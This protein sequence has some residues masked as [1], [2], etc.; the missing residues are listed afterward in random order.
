MSRALAV[1]SA[2]LVL[3]L[4][5]VL[6][7]CAGGTPA[8]APSPSPSPW[9][10]WTPTPQPTATPT[11]TPTPTVT[12]SPTPSEAAALLQQVY[13]AQ[14]TLKSYRARMAIDIDVAQR[15]VPQAVSMIIDMEVAEPDAAMKMSSEGMPLSLDMEMVMKGDVLYMKMGDEWT[16]LPGEGGL[17]EGNQA[18]APDVK[19][20]QAFFANT[21]S[22]KIMGKRTVRGIECQVIS[23]DIPPE[24]MLDLL[25]MSSGATEPPPTEDVRFDEF[26]GEVAIGIEDRMMHEMVLRMSGSQV[27]SPAEKFAMAVTITMWDI[28]SPSIVIKAPAGVAIPPALATPARRS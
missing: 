16:A 20:M 24:R 23:F 7:A 18:G 11:R 21:P 12:A 13:R 28:N 2:V 26:T 8:A 6:L 10:T 19:E 1:V 3:L 9:P 22:A 25:A 15:G 5:S 27:D 17:A 14:D 4:G